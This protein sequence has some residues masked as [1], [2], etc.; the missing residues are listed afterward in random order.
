MLAPLAATPEEQALAREAL[1]TADQEVDL[2]FESALRNA[3]EHPPALTP[4]ARK[5]DAQISDLESRVKVGQ[6][7]VAQ[8]DKQIKA[9]TDSAKEE[10]LRQEDDLTQAQPA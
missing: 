7:R 9:A 6:T 2:A 4:E 1:H 3:I 10:E 5:I 8:L